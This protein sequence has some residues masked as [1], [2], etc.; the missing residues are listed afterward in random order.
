MPSLSVNRPK[1]QILLEL[2]LSH[3]LIEHEPD[4]PIAK[5]RSR[6]KPRLRPVL[7]TLH[8]A[9]D[10]PRVIGL[11][12]KIGDTS[13]PLARAQEL[14]DAVTAF[15]AS[16]KA[17]VAWADTF[18]ESSNASVPYYLATGFREIWLQ[19]TGELNLLGVAAEVTFLRGVFDKLGVDPE[20]DQRYEYKSAADRLLRTDFT[21]A[22]REAAD[23][24]AES[25]WEQIVE[26]IAK[27]RGRAVDDVVAAA[28]RSPM[29]PD[30]ALQAGL[31]DR[32]GYRDEAYAAIRQ[33][34]KGA[35]GGD[36]GEQD[37]V[38]LL[39]A[40][41][42][43]PATRPLH[44]IVKQARQKNAPA[45]ALVEGFGGIVTG[46]SRRTPLQGPVMGS[47][48]VAATIRAAVRNDKIRAIV[49]RVDSPG[50]SA[51]ASDSIWREV[52]CAREAG[53]PVIVSMGAVAGS[54]GYYISCSADV[55]V[56]EPGTLTG[57]I[58]VLG[59]KFVTA[60][61]TERLG[62]SYKSVQRGEHARMYSTHSAF[63]ESEQERLQ[64]F[65]DRVYADFTG[66]VAKGRG[67]SAEAV[68]EVARG[69]VWTGA[70][71]ARNGLVDELGGLRDAIAL[72]RARA[73]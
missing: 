5:L 33:G 51:V 50:G 56:A 17:T 39:F 10:D 57:S 46:R 21:D 31:V 3:P 61:L 70:D 72:A 62:L 7:R 23:R 53:K 19:P 59:G 38:Q 40:D 47:D 30:E 26:G 65:L 45:V 37:E 55:I 44:R 52:V 18:G 11:I 34:A 29:F 27:A 48:T 49:F 73:G 12:A 63:G 4:D 36:S 25:A 64:A 67:M 16:G 35:R 1:P 60:G 20:M 28:D 42:W 68:H 58:G 2:D 32:L 6:G 9:G 8:E 66:K 69:R 54:G 24:L 22:H 71:A 13:M 43:A 15:A 14:R 41:K